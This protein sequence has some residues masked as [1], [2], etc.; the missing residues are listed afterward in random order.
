MYWHFFLA[1][2]SGSGT[3]FPKIYGY[4]FHPC[5]V[6]NISEEG[7]LLELTP[8]GKEKLE[9]ILTR[10]DMMEFNITA[11]QLDYDNTETRRAVWAILDKAKHK[12]GFDA[13]KG[14]IRIDALPSQNGG[15]VIFITKTERPLTEE[16]MNCEK[17]KYPAVPQ[18]AYKTIYGFKALSDLLRACCFLR[19]RE[20]S[21]ESTA[22][23]EK[24]DSRAV[25]KYYLALTQRGQYREKSTAV[26]DNMFIGEFGT[27]LTNENTFFYINEHCDCFCEKNA[28]K[29]LSDML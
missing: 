14:K 10:K 8:I 1:R 2:K 11:E 28:V 25:S 16:K 26:F 3:L 19:S 5:V 24:S 18:R 7:D 22:F 29:I 12:T 9:I 27:K 20:Y 6:Y 23:M 15:C 17:E 13:A 21:G 4:L